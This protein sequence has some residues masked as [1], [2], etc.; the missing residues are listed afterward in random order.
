[1]FTTFVLILRKGICRNQGLRFKVQR[2][3]VQRRRWPA[4]KVYPPWEGSQFNPQIS[5]ITRMTLITLRAMQNI[6]GLIHRGRKG[7]RE[8]IKEISSHRP[9]QTHTDGW[10]EREK[11]H[12]RCKGQG[13][14]ITFEPRTSEP[15]YETKRKWK[16]EPQN[17]EWQMTNNEGWNR[18]PRRRR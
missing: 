12:R 4:W 5:Q 8:K 16:S 1:M 10:A 3:R 15:S 7:R 2:F 6:Q 9:T 17:I 14:S 18:S 13:E 11:I